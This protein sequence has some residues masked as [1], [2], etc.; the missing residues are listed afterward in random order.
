MIQ[1]ISCGG[2][3]SID[4]SN[5]K[6]YPLVRGQAPSILAGA[7]GIRNSKFQRPLGNP[8]SHRRQREA[9]LVERGFDQPISL[10]FVSYQAIQRNPAIVKFDGAHRRI[11]HS[12][13]LIAFPHDK[14]GRS[15]VYVKKA[16]AAA[17]SVCRRLRR[18]N[19]SVGDPRIRYPAF[20]AI[21]HPFVAVSYGGGINTQR[22]RSAAC[23]AEGIGQYLP[24]FQRRNQDVFLQFIVSRQG[25][26][27]AALIMG[28]HDEPQ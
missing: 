6:R 24:I 16:N 9:A 26:K 5:L 12:D 23:L 14:S 22:V 25:D 18:D 15:A 21:Q 3:S 1:H 8:H 11:I 2:Y 27:I 19:I 10:V 4:I 28:T 7:A 13:H 17:S 20:G